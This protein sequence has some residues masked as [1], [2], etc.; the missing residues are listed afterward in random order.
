[1]QVL[2]QWV[3]DLQWVTVGCNLYRLADEHR[4]FVACASG[5]YTWNMLWLAT[6][7]GRESIQGGGAW[8]RWA[9]HPSETCRRTGNSDR[10]YPVQGQEIMA[11]KRTHDWK[12]ICAREYW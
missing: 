5:V 6:I 3:T 11:S 12:L 4:D 9:C 2:L 8:R 10:K 1:M 7:S